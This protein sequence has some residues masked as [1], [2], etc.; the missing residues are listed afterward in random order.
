MVE[1]NDPSG[2]AKKIKW[3][4]NLSDSEKKEM[5]D[6]MVTEVRANHN[7]ENLAKKIVNQ[8]NVKR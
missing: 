1:K 5:T 6:K 8:F 4:M 3:L 7:L 2:L